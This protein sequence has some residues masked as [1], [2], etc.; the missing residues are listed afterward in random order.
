MITSV[1]EKVAVHPLFGLQ[2]TFALA[3]IVTVWNR[4]ALTPL[5]E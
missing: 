3:G 5:D 2:F 4:E 1:P